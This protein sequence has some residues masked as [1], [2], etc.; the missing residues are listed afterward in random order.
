MLIIM[1]MHEDKKRN[2]QKYHAPPPHI[3]YDACTEVK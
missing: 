2:L 1:Y 3:K